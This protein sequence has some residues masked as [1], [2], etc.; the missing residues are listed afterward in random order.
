[1]R[2]LVLLLITVLLLS[3]CMAPK[4]QRDPGVVP[5]DYRFQSAQGQAQPDLNSLADLSWWQIFDDP[6]LQNL[7]RTALVQNYDVRLAV[8]RVAE[9]RAQVG[10]SRSSWLPDFSGTAL[11]RREKV[12]R[13]GSNPPIPPEVSVTESLAQFNFDLFWEIDIFGRLR[14]LTQAAQADFY[15]SE[16]GQRAVWAAVVADVA[17]AY[18]ELRTL[19][20]QLEIARSTLESF[21]TSRHLVKLRKRQGLVSGEDV[22]QADVLIHTAGVKIPDL[23]RQIAQKE[24]QICILLGDNPQPIQRGKSLSEL[25]VRP[26]VPAGLPSV[27]LERRPDIRQSEE[28]LIAANYRIGS[29][30]ANFFPRI[31]LTGL[32]GTR[33]VDLGKLFTGPSSI[34]NIGPTMT[35]PIFTSGFNYFTLKSTQA[36]QEQ[37]L[38]LYQLT[39]RQA[40]REVSDG[41]VAHSKLEEV[42]NEQEALVA[43]YELYSKLARKRFKGGL[44]TFLTVLDS[45]RQLFSA[46]L[47]LA[48]VHLAQL[49]TVVQLYKALGGGWEPITMHP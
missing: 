47:D 41:L 9:S 20:R 34:W 48:S 30:R 6:V 24:N 35:V 23:E 15:A 3:G 28:T 13:T 18:F 25:A 37:A 19:D 33:S 21:E 22:A 17:R 49:L 12:S 8:A 46:E 4:Y 11:Y 16:W 42:R 27:L 7:I 26:T 14:N 31:F 32:A 40:F 43:S 38:V 45:D 5:Q 10:V 1:M 44:E 36:Q 2:R 29:A 39:V